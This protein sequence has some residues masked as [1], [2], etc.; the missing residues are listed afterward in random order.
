MAYQGE[1]QYTGKRAQPSLR[2]DQEAWR[3]EDD[4]GNKDGSLHLRPPLDAEKTRRF[5]DVV[6]ERGMMG[7]NKC[8]WSAQ[9]T[10]MFHPPGDLSQERDASNVPRSA[11][12]QNIVGRCA[13][14]ASHFTPF[15][16]PLYYRAKGAKKLADSCDPNWE[17]VTKGNL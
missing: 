1:P 11:S 2:E 10:Q 15:L 17:N 8:M 3:A 13:R 14:S 7:D 16:F 9:H 4:S 12:L 5:L 6:V